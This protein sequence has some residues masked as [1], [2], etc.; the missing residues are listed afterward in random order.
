MAEIGPKGYAYKGTPVAGERMLAD[1]RPQGAL[2]PFA[3]PKAP[4][5]TA[6]RPGETPADAPIDRKAEK[7]GERAGKGQS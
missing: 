1:D 4:E 5:K 3:K 6:H 2:R 7:G